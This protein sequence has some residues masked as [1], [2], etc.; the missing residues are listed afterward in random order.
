MTARLVEATER[1][2][3]FAEHS[4]RCAPLYRALQAMRGVGTVVAATIAAELGDLRRFPSASKLMSYVGLVPSE[5]SSGPKVS[6]G[7]I[8]KA[9]NPHV[10][11]KLIQSAW[12]Y[13]HRPAISEGLERRSKGV[14]QEMRDI[15]WKAQKRLHKRY[16]SMSSRGKRPQTTI[17]AVARE[18]LGFIWAVGQ[19]VEPPSA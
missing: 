14:P 19:V 13:R 8:T 1:V 4:T 2:E 6:R 12:L 10:R 17:V 3:H 5:R 11:W 15:A 16:W 9:G 18:L 7:S